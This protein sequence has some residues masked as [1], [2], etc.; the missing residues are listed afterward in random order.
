MFCSEYD[1]PSVETKSRFGSTDAYIYV[2]V[3]ELRW[4][5]TMIDDHDYVISLKNHSFFYD[6]KLTRSHYSKICHPIRRS[7]YT[8]T[9]SY[10]N[11]PACL[12]LFMAG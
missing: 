10:A 1:C 11:V 3:V 5:P 9:R 2:S 12:T 4:I 6:A 7:D 8:L